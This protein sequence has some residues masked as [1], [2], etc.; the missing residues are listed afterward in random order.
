MGTL[1]IRNLDDRVIETLKAQAKENHRSLEGEVRHALTQRADP[2][3]R[4]EEFR[5]RTRQ[6]LSLTTGRDQTD[7]VGLLREDRNR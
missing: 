1:T 2:L 3:R 4:V 6:L 7:S 5:G